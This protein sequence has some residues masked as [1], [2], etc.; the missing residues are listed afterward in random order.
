[1]ELDSGPPS[2]VSRDQHQVKLTISAL[3]ALE[4]VTLFVPVKEAKIKRSWVYV[5]SPP[6]H[7]LCCMHN[8]SAE[9]ARVSVVLGL[10]CT[11]TYRGSEAIS[12][13]NDSLGHDMTHMMH[14]AVAACHGSQLS[15]IQSPAQCCSEVSADELLPAVCTYAVSMAD[16]VEEFQ[17][18]TVATHWER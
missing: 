15:P 17:D 1:M 13:T 9:Q 11:M 5:P 4:L 18:F 14:K 12:W 7:S 10:G 8:A 6:T 2:Q 16:E 3:S